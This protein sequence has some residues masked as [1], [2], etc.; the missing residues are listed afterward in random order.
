MKRA[1][2]FALSVVLASGSLATLVVACYLFII[3]HSLWT[4]GYHTDRLQHHEG[5]PETWRDTLSYLG[6]L[7]LFSLP[8]L[9]VLSIGAVGSL[10][11]YKLGSSALRPAGH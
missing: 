7:L 8:A 9:F 2:Q 4:D 11:S 1:L 10:I 3:A 6:G 5:S